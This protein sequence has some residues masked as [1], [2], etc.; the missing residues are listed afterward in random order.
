MAK[1]TRCIYVSPAGVR[2]H[3]LA[4]TP[5]HYC[6]M[7]IEHEAEYQTKRKE[8][9]VKHTQQY[10]HNYNKTQRVRNDTKWE[11]DKFYRTKQWTN[12]LRPAVLERDNYLCQYCKANGRMTPGKIVDHIIPYEFDPSKRDDLSNLATICAACHTG[13]TR[14]EQ[15]YYGTGAGNELKNV[16][17]VPDIKYLP[18]FMDSAKTQ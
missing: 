9:S 7:H 11:Q 13:K 17:A 2:C 5:N 16:A 6:A 3:R 8:W 1:M 14:W 4:E 15:E 12:G 10:Y 18:D